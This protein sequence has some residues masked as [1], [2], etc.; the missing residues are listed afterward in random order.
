M[1]LISPWEGGYFDGPLMESERDTIRVAGAVV[2]GVA[3]VVDIRHV[4]RRRRG[5]EPPV[6]AFTADNRGI[7]K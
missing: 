4:R 3:V 2:V 6:A 1:A 5:S 7:R